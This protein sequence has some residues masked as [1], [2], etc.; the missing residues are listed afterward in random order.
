MRKGK[1]RQ[2]GGETMEEDIP[3]IHDDEPEVSPEVG[4]VPEYSDI[5]YT[6]IID[7]SPG[8]NKKG[9]RLPIG[10]APRKSR[11]KSLYKLIHGNE[12][13]LF[14]YCVE[15]GLLQD[16]SKLPCPQC[17]GTSRRVKEHRS[18]EGVALA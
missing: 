12:S 2:T 8:R 11:G 16:R 4:V 18:G 6:R 13:K 17:G 1:R 14:W 9:K 3:G 10:R 5:L 15:I 7:R